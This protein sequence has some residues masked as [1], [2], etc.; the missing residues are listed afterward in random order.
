MGDLP[1]GS[2]HSRAFGVSADGNTIVGE[3]NS[4]NGREA[5][6]Y[7][8]G[9]GIA[10]LGDLSGGNF[11]SLAHAVS[12]GVIVGSSRS[13]G[14]RSEAFR[15]TSGSGMNGI[16][17]L[18][19]GVFSSTALGVSADGNVIVGQGSGSSFTFEAFRSTNGVMV[20]LGDLSGGGFHSA[21]LGV[22][23]DGSIIVGSGTSGNGREAFRFT[24][25]SGM[26]GLGDLAG[27]VFESSANDISADGNV[28]VG[29]GV[30]GN[31]NTEAFRHTSN[32]GMVGLGFLLGG[33]SS[34]AQGVSGDGAIIVGDAGGKAFIWDETS[35]AMQSIQDILIGN[36]FDLSGW[37]LSQARAIS[38]DGSTVVGFG[39]H[40]GN[41]EAFYARIGP[42]PVPVPAAVWLMGSA[43]LGLVGFKR[44]KVG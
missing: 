16:G 28:I 11:D 42:A 22:S 1:G 10:G 38:D 17:D 40:N 29:Y 18:A 21:A 36:G 33:G 32:G 12:S 2:T 31:G 3:S 20:G 27:G 19:G 6:R 43:L 14:N 26:V 24:S 7:I 41:T 39:S 44:K 25:G 37:N 34:S 13:V 23:A 35:N 5:F 4:A 8:I 30:S 9:S 15:F